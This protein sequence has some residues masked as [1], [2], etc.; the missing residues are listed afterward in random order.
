MLD[1]H[2]VCSEDAVLVFSEIYYENGWNA[3]LDGVYHP[4]FKVNYVLRAAEVPAGKH[5]IEFR[6]EPE[7]IQIGSQITIGSS[8]ALLL[9]FLGGI[10]YSIR[11]NRVKETQDD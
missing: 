1:V 6:F 5:K 4:H 11:R 10:V 2:G 8:I 3:Y 9:V 7:L